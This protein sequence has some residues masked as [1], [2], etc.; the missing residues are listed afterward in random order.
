MKETLPPAEQT[1]PARLFRAL[2]DLYTPDGVV[3][4]GE[5]TNKLPKQ[6]VNWLLSDGLIQEEVSS[7][8]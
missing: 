5:L 4:A 8:V 7:G 1:K 3:K 6:S 2:V